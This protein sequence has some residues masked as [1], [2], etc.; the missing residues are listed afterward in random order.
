MIQIS[1]CMTPIP[2]DVLPARALWKLHAQLKVFLVRVPLKH[3]ERHYCCLEMRLKCSGRSDR[4][5]GQ[6]PRLHAQN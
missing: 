3:L 6:A 4:C 1:Y 2:V 5:L